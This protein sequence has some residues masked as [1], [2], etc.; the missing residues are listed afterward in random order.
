MLKNEYKKA[1]KTYLLSL[2]LG[3]N[4]AKA[5]VNASK[6]YKNLKEYDKAIKHLKQAR[7]IYSFERFQSKKN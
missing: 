2:M 6:A 3:K 1:A 4:D 7:N 5:R